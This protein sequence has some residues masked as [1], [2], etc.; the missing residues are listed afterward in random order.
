M[1]PKDAARDSLWRTAFSEYGRGVC[2]Y[3]T[4]KIHDEIMRGLPDELRGE[5]W[6]VYSGAINEVRCCILYCKHIDDAKFR[7]SLGKYNEV[8]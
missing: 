2:M 8:V 3:R 6:M 4:K 1:S 7:L 5:M